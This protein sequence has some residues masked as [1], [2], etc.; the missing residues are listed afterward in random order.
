M[1]QGVLQSLAPLVGGGLA[2][3]LHHRRINSDEEGHWTDAIGVGGVR[4]ALSFAVLIWLVPAGALLAVPLLL[5]LS[6]LSPAGRQEWS[7]QRTPRLLAL[8]VAFLC[9]GSHR[10]SSCFPARLPG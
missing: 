7:V 9:L 8:C 10:V 6:L 2:L 5:M 3:N 4:M 1:W